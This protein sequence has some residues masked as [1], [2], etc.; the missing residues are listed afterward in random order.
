[1]AAIYKST[2]LF[3]IQDNSEDFADTIKFL[4]NRFSDLAQIYKL[5]NKV[6]HNLIWFIKFDSIHKILSTLS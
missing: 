6:I 2:E 3:M 1:M 5:K 4:D